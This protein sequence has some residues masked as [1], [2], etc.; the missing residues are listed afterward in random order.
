VALR[1]RREGQPER[2]LAIAEQAERRS[3]GRY[4]RLELRGKHTN[5]VVIATKGE[6]RGLSVRQGLAEFAI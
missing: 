2:V 6:T 5:K 3:S 1:K 4:V